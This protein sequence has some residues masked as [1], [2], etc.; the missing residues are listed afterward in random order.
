MALIRTTFFGLGLFFAALIAFCGTFFGKL[1]YDIDSQTAANEQLAVSITRELS[2]TWSLDSLKPH[3]GAAVAA[4]LD[5]RSAQAS[6]DGFKAL[7]ALLYVDDVT[8]RTGLNLKT[9]EGAK[10]P[11]DFA[12]FLSELLAKKATVSFLGKF[13]HGR[14]RVSVELRSE[15][16]VLRLWHLQIDRLGRPLPRKM[17]R[18]KVSIV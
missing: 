1:A 5:K 4:S 3:Y 9:L 7:G 16:G 6:L 2:Q 11:A 12:L 13:E 15:N 18:R 17:R 14:A 8:L 10:S